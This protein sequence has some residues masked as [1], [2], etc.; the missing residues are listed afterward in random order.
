[1]GIFILIFTFLAVAATI[2]WL[3][4]K[5]VVKNT[6]P[7]NLKV[8]S[9]LRAVFNE[10]DAYDNRLSHVNGTSSDLELLAKEEYGDT[11]YGVINHVTGSNK[12]ISEELLLK[13]FDN[14]FHE[15]TR[16]HVRGDANNKTA[17]YKCA[18]IKGAQKP[19]IAYVG[20]WSM[21]SNA[22][23]LTS[24]IS[25]RFNDIFTDSI[26]DTGRTQLVHSIVVMYP[27]A[28]EESIKAAMIQECIDYATLVRKTPPTENARVYE[29]IKGRF[30]GFDHRPIFLSKMNWV[31][32]PNELEQ[33]YA[34][35]TTELCNERYKI[36]A[37]NIHKAMSAIVSKEGTSVGFHG[38]PGTGKT[39][40]MMDSVQLLSSQLEDTVFL[41]ANKDMIVTMSKT[42]EDLSE[43]LISGK[44]NVLVLDEADELI[45]KHESLF[46]EITDGIRYR[47]I[48][49]LSLIFSF[50][51][52]RNN[53]MLRNGRTILFDVPPLKKVD[54]DKIA[55][56]LYEQNSETNPKVFL[57]D[58]YL[59][60]VNKKSD[61][62]DITLDQVYAFHRDKS[63]IDIEKLVTEAIKEITTGA[64]KASVAPV[65]PP[66]PKSDNKKDNKGRK[67]Q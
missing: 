35:M 25:K 53:P 59:A 43:L 45:E 4:Y 15:V 56:R 40:I 16:I 42:G 18:L 32:F 10:T 64:A 34:T 62:E 24:E 58:K 29:L 7:K 19:S 44:R 14:Y 66:A 37:E 63:I 2:I 46:K 48:Y 33:N 3:Y 20:V 41:L 31:L 36:P 1:M 51:N 65:N 38:P 54:I 67:R 6:N 12:P 47:H 55:H 22:Q 23:Y 30:G 61:I 11:S 17:F 49:K 39:R 27:N 50:N 52:D 8:S 28:A 5:F 13:E 57:L 26:N 21:L 60:W 9:T